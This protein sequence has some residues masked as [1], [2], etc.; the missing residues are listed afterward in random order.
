MSDVTPIRVRDPLTDSL[1]TPENPE[2]FGQISK[3]FRLTLNAPL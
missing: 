3:Q 2:Q 1:I